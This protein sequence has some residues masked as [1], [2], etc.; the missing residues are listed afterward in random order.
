MEMEKAEPSNQV[1]RELSCSACF[2]AV[3]FCY[4]PKH[5]LQ[6]YYRHAK[7]DDCKDKWNALFD[8][9]HL[10]TKPSSEMQAILESREKASQHIWEFRTV[11][12]A[13][14]EWNKAY[15]HLYEN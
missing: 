10:K 13:S 14:K 5:Q 2:D 1:R 4:S 7:L 15:G 12:D 11:D 9:F 6:Q 3:W 8:C